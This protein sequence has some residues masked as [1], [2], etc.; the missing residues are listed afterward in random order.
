MEDNITVSALDTFCRDIA[1]Q[2]VKV[3]AAKEAYDAEKKVLEEMKLKGLAHLEAL[4]RENY[5]S[6]YCT[7]YT[8]NNF[9]VKVPSNP[10]DRDKFF[11]WMKEK[12]IFEE[13]ITVHSKTLVSMYN[14]FVEESGDPDFQIPGITEIKSYET[15]SIRSK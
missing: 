6:E 5:K 13:K 14:S 12:G 2:N 9:S 11:T 10:Y 7:I 8:K 3:K 4:D 15:L 1:Q